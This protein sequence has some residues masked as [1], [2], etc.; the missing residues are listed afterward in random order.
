M[1][2]LKRNKAS[3]ILLGISSLVVPNAGFVP[4]QMG[5]HSNLMQ[6]QDGIPGMEDEEVE[7]DLGLSA[8]RLAQE[9][10]IKI[11]GEVTHKPGQAEAQP[12]ELLRYTALNKVEESTIKSVMDK[13][14]SKIICSGQG[15]EEYKDPGN[16]LEKIVILAP[17][18]AIKDAFEKAGPAIDSESLVFNFLGGDDLM[19][20]EVLDAAKE[21]ALMMDIATKAKISFNS[22]CHK[23]IPC[24]TCTITVVSL[25]SGA[26]DGADGVEKSIAAGEVYLR[27]GTYMTVQESEINTALA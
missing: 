20:G 4:R 14:G 18:E 12:M 24:G 22:L 5:A 23:S 17:M 13:T 10:A 25:G 2:A 9:S 6:L 3:L 8:I 21:I 16:T 11:T 26:Y 27:D 15:V 7:A 19:M 1:P